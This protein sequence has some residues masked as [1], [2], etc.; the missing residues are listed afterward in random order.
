VI[1]D[2]ATY[3]TQVYI[4][5]DESY[6]EIL[7]KL[8][9][10]Y[11]TF[12]EPELD[13]SVFNEKDADIDRVSLNREILEDSFKPVEVEKP[14]PVEVEKPKPVKV[15]KPK[16]V[17]VEKPKP[18]PIEKPKPVKVEKPKPV[19]VTKP[20]VEDDLSFLDDLDNIF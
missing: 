8:V 2:G 14:K 4:R 7:Q 16:P 3:T 19:K 10:Q 15:E 5:D 18:V 12:V 20:K 1:T 17:K 11:D 6:S 13:W 9:E